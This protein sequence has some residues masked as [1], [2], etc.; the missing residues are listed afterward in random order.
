ML[1]YLIVAHR[2][3]SSSLFCLAYI[4]N[5]SLRFHILLINKRLMSLICRIIMRCYL[6]FLIEVV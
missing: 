3:C 4:S 2:L 1:V 5:E 6:S